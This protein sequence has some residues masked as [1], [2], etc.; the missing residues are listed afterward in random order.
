MRGGRYA[1]TSG[2]TEPITDD[3]RDFGTPDRS[4]GGFLLAGHHRVGVD[5]PVFVVTRIERKLPQLP[6]PPK[7][8]GNRQERFLGRREKG[9]YSE[10]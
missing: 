7:H 10:Y 5:G 3:A 9:S 6:H 4:A 1:G 2:S 8:P